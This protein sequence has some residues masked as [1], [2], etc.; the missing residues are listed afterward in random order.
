[1]RKRA[2]L[3]GSI[4]R[5]GADG[6]GGSGSVGSRDGR[7]M[8]GSS[9]GERQGWRGMAVA[10][11]HAWGRGRVPE[12]WGRALGLHFP[13]G[14]TPVAVLTLGLMKLVS[15]KTRVTL[16][17]RRVRQSQWGLPGCPVSMR[18]WGGQQPCLAGY[19]HPVAIHREPG[20]LPESW[21]PWKSLGQNPCGVPS[22]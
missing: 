1:M 14:A 6:H 5:P 12:G 18:V 17:R 3:S 22:Q 20:S 7:S 8:R 2:T 19:S 21:T 11:H 16:G 9:G 13:Q 15:G 10:P 4:S